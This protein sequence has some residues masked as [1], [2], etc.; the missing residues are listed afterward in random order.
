[1]FLVGE[2]SHKIEAVFCWVRGGFYGFGLWEVKMLWF[3]VMRETLVYS[4][5]TVVHFTTTLVKIIKLQF[6]LHIA[7]AEFSNNC[8][9]EKI[10]S[11][12]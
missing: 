2:F 8:S 10:F 3:W 6:D 4:L 5:K 12:Y 7:S 1:M 9:K 11:D